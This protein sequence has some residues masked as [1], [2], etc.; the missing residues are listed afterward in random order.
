[1]ENSVMKNNIGG[2][3]C[4]ALHL[5]EV[6]AVIIGC[7]F[8][9]NSVN[10]GLAIYG[11]AALRVG[12][13]STVTVETTEFNENVHQW[14]AGETYTSYRETCQGGGAVSINAKNGYPSSVTF[15]R[16]NFSSNWRSGPLFCKGGDGGAISFRDDGTEG[17]SS[18]AIVGCS[19]NGNLAPRSG[20][21]AL[22]VWGQISC[23]IHDS[24][25]SGN[26]AIKSEE[27]R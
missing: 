24:I 26:T 7:L 4:G 2:G 12:V 8:Q 16:S 27:A 10:P 14:N 1:M 23:F 11:G 3:N 15:I 9:S 13:G 17:I 19:F 6:T 25:F 21:G 22:V 18:L 20:G 5:R